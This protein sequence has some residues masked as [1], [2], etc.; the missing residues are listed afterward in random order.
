MGTL[1]PEQWKEASPY[2]DEAVC[3]SEQQ[4]GEWL[5]SFRGKK[6]ELAALLEAL[7]SEHRA[8]AEEGFLE[9]TPRLAPGQPAE[10]SQVVGAY[11]LLSAIGE[12]GMGTVWLAER[13]DGRFDR[14]V[15]V[16]FP[17][18]ALRGRSGEERFKREGNILGRLAHPNIAELLDA[19]V[20]A[21]GQ[22]YIVLEYVDGERI[23]EYCRHYRVGV[24]G[25]IRL[26]LDVLSAVAHAHTNLIVHRD[27]K[28]SNVLVRS[29]GQVKL[30]DF[31]IAK[32]LEEHGQKREATL[33]TREGGSLLT[34]E[35]AAPEQITGTP[36]TTATDVYSLGV[37]L[38]M[39]LAG[40]HPNGLGPRSPADLFKAIL[41]T[42]PPP[43]SKAVSPNSDSL[44][45][46]EATRTADSSKL[47]RR[48]RGDLD[49][50]VAKALKK[51]PQERY[52]SV[53]AF[54]DDLERY[55]RYEPISARPDTIRYRTAKFVR[56]NR[57][58]VVL[59]TLALIAVIAG[60]TGTLIQ[61]RTA[62]RQRDFA[63]SE[64]D[65]ANRITDFMTG[66]F[67]VSDPSETV[68][69]G[70]TA[71]EILE[72]ASKDINAGL[73]KDPEL[74]AQMMH[75]MGN[76]YYNLGL[77]DQAQSLLERAIQVNRAARGPA[78]PETL[79]SLESLG[80]VLLQQGHPA[81][82]EQLQQEALYLQRRA[83]GPEHPDTLSTMSDLAATLA[84]E[85]RI[86]EA[87]KLG[88][89]ALEKQ[90]RVLGVE[91][92][93][94]IA[95]MD[96]LAAMLG[97]SGR[98][99]ESEQLERETIDVERRVY[100]PDHLGVLNSMGNLADTLY[101][102]GR[103]AEAEQLWRQT[104]DIQRRVLGPDHPETARSTYNLGCL[105]ARK[106]K[107]D[108]ALSLLGQAIDRLSPRTVPKLDN[109]PELNSLHAD[110]RFDTLVARA[111][112]RVVSEARC[113]L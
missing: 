77:Y 80:G 47:R 6:P 54:A 49:T 108:E 29:R 23:D 14:K 59:A 2:L 60:V 67:K 64:R 36:V 86:E 38:Y 75:V 21:T 15:A 112:R 72:K 9:Q 50:I 84:E 68:G 31:G 81:R 37:L 40:K 5:A 4:R 107:R 28:P 17:H 48:F 97:V 35:Y 7:L 113:P 76:V 62:R 30:L 63:F 89:E 53:T 16:K 18:I 69:N 10:V 34:P 3:L 66:M 8:L 42:E 32:L 22:P 93:H 13:S 20:S 51:S 55:L 65:R 111:R 91:D 87:E 99:A 79:S 105:A 94:T 85:G 19:G 70:V 104:L 44:A 25:R 33:L 58:A 110:P 92:H 82:A 95:T 43:L 1:S 61:A 57:T 24:E 98:F 74:Q 27:I 52:A 96:N 41:E 100:G 83:L 73:A 106:G 46:G 103:Y 39:L 101:F 71:R 11:R 26:F 78:D 88:R 109:D 102:M 12:G 90:R 56:R 45:E